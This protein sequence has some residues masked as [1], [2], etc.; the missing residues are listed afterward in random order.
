MLILK[1]N[2]TIATFLILSVMSFAES[3][4]L[5]GRT[6]L[7]K[8]SDIG[9]VSDNWKQKDFNDLQWKIGKAPLGYGD[10]F[11]E[12]D[13]TIPVGTNIEFGKAEEKFMTSYFRKEINVSNINDIKEL[14]VFLHVDDGAV[15][16]IN[17]TEAFRRG[18]TDEI[19]TYNSLG[20]FKPKEETFIIPKS[21]LITGKNII[22]AE[23]HQDSLNSSDLWFE[24]G[25]KAILNDGVK[26]DNQTS[27]VQE[28]KVK[29]V[30]V[31]TKKL[32]KVT[33]TF[34]GDTQTTKGF[35]WYTSQDSKKSDL[36]I[37]EKTEATPDFSKAIEFKG[38]TTIPT[39]SPKEYLHK[40]E[41]TNLSSG[42]TYYFRVGDKKLNLWSDTGIF[43]TSNK[44][45]KFTFI[46]YADTQAKSEDE[47]ILSA[48]TLKKAFETVKN[49]EF[50]VHNGDI[51]DTGMNEIQWNWLIGHSQKTLLNTTIA[52]IAGNHEE[53]KDAF[54]EHFNIKEAP[55]SDTTTGAYYS[56]DYENTH[57][58][59]LNT[60]EDSKEFN[61]FSL[62]Q[63]EWLKKDALSA[64]KRGLK[65]IIAT[66]HKGPYTTSNHATDVDIMG[67]N[68]VRTK[69]ATLFD[70]IGVDLVFQGHDHI[71]ARTK[72]LKDGKSEKSNKVTE[73]ID[74][75]KVEFE[76]NPNGTVYMI[77]STG[78]PK[79][80]YK[81]KKIDA[82]YYDLFEKADEHSA[83]KYGA[84]P[85]DSSRPL[86]GLIQNFAG[87]NI[88][89]N[90]L[91][92][93]V[94]EID[95]QGNKVPYIIDQYGIIKK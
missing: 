77:P 7:W 13:P 92:V 42:K 89:N 4:E 86:R 44:D 20:K 33:V 70:D 94:Y 29:E 79:V 34:T 38:T 8:Y 40:A 9:M 22:S 71:Y 5:V 59:M 82:T 73:M 1:K 36:Q 76:K 25:I 26:S 37:V 51:V 46:D 58:I 18:I 6:E 78:G 19:V 93:T 41:A 48:E 16:Y 15:V 11:S 31:E 23:V 52:P 56:Y 61:N 91:T 24:L 88:D 39:N 57:F 47:A 43:T 32:A 60:N 87:I 27:A 90:K 74:G 65:W 35:T 45:N 28:I 75:K 55:G 17:G 81:N 12:T 64:K 30:P 3:K 54:I 21:L 62:E 80:Y 83:A 95:Q 84:D 2:A 50:V 69:V 68:G 85:K 63:I 72:V 66:I 14:E 49:A 67:P 53:E 10:D